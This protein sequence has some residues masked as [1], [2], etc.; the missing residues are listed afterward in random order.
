MLEPPLW[1]F[2]LLFVCIGLYLS[3]SVAQVSLELII[4][5]PKQALNSQVL[6][7]AI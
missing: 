1:I 5:E 6:R 2:F 7:L 4:M 3:H